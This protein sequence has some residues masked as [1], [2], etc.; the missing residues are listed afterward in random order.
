MGGTGGMEERLCNSV[1]AVV[2]G[3][4]LQL[5]IGW[6]FGSSFLRLIVPPSRVRVSQGLF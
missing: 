3:M 1:V 4:R 5:L 2:V 6:L